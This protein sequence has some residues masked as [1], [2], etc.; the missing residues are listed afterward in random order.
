MSQNH[1]PSALFAI[2][3]LFLLHGLADV[4]VGIYRCHDVDRDLTDVLAASL[5][6]SQL[7]LLAIWLAAGSE[8]LSW[9][10][11]GL[12]AGGCFVFIVF[13]RFVFPG[14]EDIWRNVYWYDE[15][16]VYYFRLSGPGDV[17]IKA[18]ILIG[19]VVGPLLI[20]RGWRAIRSVRKSGLP[21]VKL[22]RWIQFQFRMQDVFVW[23]VTLSVALAATYR[24]APY[25]GWYGDLI[26]RWREVSRLANPPDVY[27]AVSAALYV[28]V[29]CVSLWSVYSRM[30]LRF[31]IPIA[32]AL[33][34]APALG[35]EAWL[36]HVTV[37]ATSQPLPEVWSHAS[38][39]TLI[40]LVAAT[41]MVG[42]LLLV[43]LYGMVTVR[44]RRR[45]TVA[46][47]E[48]LPRNDG[49]EKKRG[50]APEDDS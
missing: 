35:F 8:R 32:I 38:P 28:L 41:V 43:R 3:W 13:S 6:R 1:A 22:A 4:M 25:P 45:T 16:W 7:C 33:V 9:R 39:E 18:P 21:R 40:S 14:A 49:S 50:S 37:Q 23:I 29:A 34:L 2:G 26:G 44:R 30:S 47:G 46:F 48:D 42:S 36:R 27:C 12:I 17:L 15:E 31:R 5:T 20:W 10:I 19:G 11:C 24:T